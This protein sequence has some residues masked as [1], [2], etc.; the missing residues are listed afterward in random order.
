MPESKQWLLCL[1]SRGRGKATLDMFSFGHDM[2][3]WGM[4]TLDMFKFQGQGHGNI[5]HV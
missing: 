3:S 5:G 4:A 1:D 2:F